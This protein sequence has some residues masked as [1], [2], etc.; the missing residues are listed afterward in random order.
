M[1]GVL[2]LDLS[3]AGTG[4]AF[5]EDLSRQP[6]TGV[7]I[8]AGDQYAFGRTWASLDNQ[9]A[10]LLKLL[11]P[12]KIGIEA[13]LPPRFQTTP[14]SGRLAFGLTATAEQTA[15]RFS[16]E[17]VLVKSETARSK[18]TGR[19]YLNEDE[20]RAGLTVKSGIVAPWVKSMGWDI[21]DH[22]ARDA[23]VGL[24]YMLGYRSRSNRRMA[25]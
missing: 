1:S 9:L 5:G 8:L 18:V 14:E 6:E 3:R 11:K 23:A 16:I 10:G 15:Y 21:A 24:A 25:A 12:S 7:W 22:N 2:F 4:F 20:K 13:P 19:A 17:C